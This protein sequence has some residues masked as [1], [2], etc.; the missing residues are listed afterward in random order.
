MKNIPEARDAT[1]L[2]PPPPPPPCCCCYYCCSLLLSNVHLKSSKKTLVVQKDTKHT[3]AQDT[4]LKPQ[5]PVLVWLL[6]LMPAWSLVLVLVACA[7]R[8]CGGWYGVAKLLCWPSMVLTNVSYSAWNKPANLAH[9]CGFANRWKNTH[10]HARQTHAR[11]PV[12]API[13]V[14][15]TSLVW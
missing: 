15:I 1:R 11:K 8:Q 5:L 2:E 13:P 4:R 14:F 7:R 10:P 9:G 3:W 12:Q 6:V